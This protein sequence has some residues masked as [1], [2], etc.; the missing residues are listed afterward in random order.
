MFCPNCGA[1]SEAGAAFCNHCGASL[2]A[3]PK[4]KAPNTAKRNK[5]LLFGGIGVVAVAAIVV[6]IVLLV[7]GGKGYG[8]PEEAAEN[9]VM[10]ERT[11]DAKLF[12]DCLPDLIVD[13]YAR[14]YGIPSGSRSELIQKLEE[15]VDESDKHTCMILNSVVNNDPE[16]HLNFRYW[17]MEHFS[18][19]GVI[20]EDLCFV[21]I[22]ALVDDKVQEYSPACVK[23][24]G[25]W[26]A[27]GQ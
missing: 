15:I 11:A 3:A 24:N 1:Q 20:V 6:V 2:S 22:I 9:F 23:I 8:S 18:S 16:Y 7:T 12:V 13:Q 17:A 10:A 19:K 27:F 26:F 4:V 5:L 14:T 21:D 25:R